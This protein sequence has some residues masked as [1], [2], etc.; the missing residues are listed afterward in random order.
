VANDDVLRM[1]IHYERLQTLLAQVAATR[2]E[3]ADVANRPATEI[4]PLVRIFNGMLE[5][6]AQLFG[7]DP[8]VVEVLQDL[9]PVK[10]V[11][12][13]TSSSHMRAKQDLTFSINS[14]LQVFGAKL[15]SA[16]GVPANVS[17]EREGLFIAGQRFDALLAATRMLS[18]ARAS[19][20]LVDGY[21]SDSVLNLLSAKGESVTIQIITKR[22][23]CRA[24]SPLAK[25]FNSQYGM[26]APL[27]IRTSDAFHDRFLVIDDDQLYHFGASLKD[28]GGRGFM[29]SKIE[30]PS[31]VRL[32]KQAID[33]EWLKA[34][35]VI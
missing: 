13:L 4:P 23:P 25:A 20:R 1:R 10:G 19:I 29:F 15:N 24:T 12:G 5:R 7:S 3:M 26:V 6:T 30:E 9:Q 32:L 11:E 22:P 17:I 34:K 8:L 2:P 14:L 18:A 16:T 33:E 28:L 21:I 27:S 31:I 35:V